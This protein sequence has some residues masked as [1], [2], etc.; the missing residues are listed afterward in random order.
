MVLVDVGIKKEQ[1]ESQNQSIAIIRILSINK[2]GLPCKIPLVRSIVFRVLAERPGKTPHI[3]VTGVDASL[4]NSFA[5]GE[6]VTSLPRKC[7]LPIEFHPVPVFAQDV[8]L[9]MLDI[10]PGEALAVM[11]PVQLHQNSERSIE[12]YNNSDKIL[13]MAR[14][15]SPKVVTLVDLEFSPNGKPFLARF[16]ETLDFYAHIFYSFETMPRVYLNRVT[17]EQHY[18]GRKSVNIIACMRG[19]NGG[20]P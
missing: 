2:V 15:L 19:R 17:I 4:D 16:A 14:S 20:A 6:W 5:V 13:R 10:R 7:M 12:I 11:F 3:R 1:I 8:T 18:L 9:E